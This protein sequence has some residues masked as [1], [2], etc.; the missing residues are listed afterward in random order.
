MTLN[1]IKYIRKIVNESDV[2]TPSPL[3][4]I[5][6]IVISKDDILYPDIDQW[7]FIFDD[8]EEI[9]E[10]FPVKLYSKYYN[11]PKGTDVE[12]SSNYSKPTSSSWDYYIDDKNILRIYEY[13]VDRDGLRFSNFFGY[14]YIVNIVPEK[15]VTE[16]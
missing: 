15:G 11:V 12:N 2:N 3:L 6:S 7:R 9:L 16:I 10:V 8:D 14:N 4:N 13:L 1:Q 5:F